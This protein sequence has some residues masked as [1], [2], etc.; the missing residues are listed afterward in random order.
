MLTYQKETKESVLARLEEHRELD[1]IVQGLYW[2]GNGSWKGCA[3]GCLTHD[4]KGGHSAFPELWGIPVQLAY[5]I[6]GLFEALPLEEAKAWPQRIMSAIPVGADLSGVWDRWALW[7]LVDP[8]YG[9]ARVAR[10]SR[11][12]VEAMG[13]LFQRAVDG[14]EPSEEEWRE[15][16]GA[17][18]AARVAWAA[19][20]AWAAWAVRRAAWAAEAA[21]AA[22]AAEAAEAAWAAE[23]AEAATVQAQCDE[24]VRLCEA[25]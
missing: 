14:D 17:A 22:R 18:E 4:P 8:E 7:M 10:T 13:A 9:V 23:A 15:A 16:A 1:E 19:E 3:V 25:A 21:W 5:L 2:V 24:L 11:G 20:A 12:V 6:D